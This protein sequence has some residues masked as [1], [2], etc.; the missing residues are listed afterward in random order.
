MFDRALRGDTT[1]AHLWVGLATAYEALGEPDR[2][3]ATLEARRAV[4][5][6]RDSC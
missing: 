4:P 6:H 1:D 3:I 2:Q 5:R